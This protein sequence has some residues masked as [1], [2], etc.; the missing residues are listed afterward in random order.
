MYLWQGTSPE[1][2][3]WLRLKKSTFASCYH[4]VSLMLGAL[5]TWAWAA[6]LWARHDGTAPHRSCRFSHSRMVTATSRTGM[7][8]IPGQEHAAEVNPY[9]YLT[10]C[11]S[12]KAHPWETA[13]IWSPALTFAFS[14]SLFDGQR[15]VARLGLGLFS[16]WTLWDI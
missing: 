11:P 6:G 9:A 4:F 5:L 13:T 2:T 10:P 14:Q 8:L 12:A 7:L 3:L 16:K 15:N 1:A